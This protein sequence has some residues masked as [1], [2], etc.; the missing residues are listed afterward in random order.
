VRDE[1]KKI[2]TYISIVFGSFLL[3]FGIFYYLMPI[4]VRHSKTIE[5]PYLKHMSIEKAKTFI[6]SL[7][8]KYVIEDSVN[9]SEVAKGHIVSS[10]P[11]AKEDIKIGG[12]IKLVISKGPK[13]IRLPNIIGISK[14]NAL[15]SLDLLGITNRVFVNYPVQ[16]KNLDGKI[17]KTRPE[18]EDSIEEGGMLTI[19]IGA[20]KRKVFLMPNL[21]GMLLEE[22]EREIRRHGLILSD[23]KRTTGKVD[24]VIQQ[25]PAPGVEVTL[26]DKVKIVVGQ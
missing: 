12:V 20:E 5:V 25:S 15:D 8:L 24:V 14:K 13:K 22:A 3:G 11:A 26:E 10:D 9:S 19:Y 23:V 4:I 1:V 21:N 16:E 18:I 7:N 17:V 2:F 6:P